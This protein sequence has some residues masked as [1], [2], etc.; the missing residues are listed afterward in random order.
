MG[1]GGKDW[2]RVRVVV[3]KHLKIATSAL[4][5]INPHWR[6]DVQLTN[7]VDLFGEVRVIVSLLIM[8]DVLSTGVT[9]SSLG[10]S[11]F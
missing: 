11:E 3:S 2:G 10:L 1:S 4:Y 8:L 6:R 5:L 9:V 7:E